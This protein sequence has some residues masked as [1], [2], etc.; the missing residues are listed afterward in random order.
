MKK[1]YTAPTMMTVEARL[2]PLMD[3][4]SG[5]GTYNIGYGGVDINGSEEPG[6]RYVNSLWDDENEE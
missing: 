6:A 1:Q 5:S 2:H 4:V 3:S